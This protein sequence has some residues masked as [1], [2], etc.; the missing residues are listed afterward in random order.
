MT[1]TPILATLITLAPFAFAG[2]LARGVAPTIG[3]FMQFD[4]TP[5][6]VSFAEMK[7]EVAH[8]MDETGLRL[9]WRFVK[10]NRGREGFSDL[11]VVR[12]KGKCEVDA[13]SAR[14][15]S[16]APFSEVVTLASTQVSD[17]RVLPFTE[18]ECDQVRRT[19]GED[20]VVSE[21][22]KQSL[23][24]KA[25]G[26]V[27]AHELYHLLAQTTRHTERGLAKATQ[28]WRDMASGVLRFEGGESKAMRQGVLQHSMSFV[29]AK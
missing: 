4:S 26:R 8:I 14:A 28:D 17:G 13:P 2:T 10:D 9:N 20:E 6:P 3:I 23:L 1:R 15:T 19:L 7:K 27:V 5:S 18:V 24:G 21:H 12:F 25:M 11:I 29:P 22:Q 16:F